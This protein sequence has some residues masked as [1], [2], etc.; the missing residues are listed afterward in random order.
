M[1]EIAVLLVAL[2]LVAMLVWARLRLSNSSPHTRLFATLWRA[3]P[4]DGDDHRS[5]F[6]CT[7]SPL[8][9]GKKESFG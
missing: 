5:C 1:K 7:Q 8:H 6:S 9:G 2:V 3:I 4:A